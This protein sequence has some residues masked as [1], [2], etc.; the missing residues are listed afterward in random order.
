MDPSAT[1]YVDRDGAALAYQVTGDGPVDMV[2]FFEIC[3]HLDLQWTD[4]D[5]HHNFQHISTFARNVVFQRRGFGLSEQVPY[6]PTL[7]QQAGDVLAIMDAAGMRRA[8]LVGWMTTCGAV[9]LVAATAP[10]RVDALVLVDPVAQGPE[11]PG[12]LHGWTDGEKQKAAEALRLAID[13]WGTGGLV[14]LFDPAL[15]TGFNRQLMALLERSSATPAAA[16][17]NFDLVGQLDIEDILPSV[18]APTLVLG[19]LVSAWPE[20]AVR[21]VADLIPSSTFHVLPPSP[22]GTSLGRAMLPVMD[23][24]EEVATGVSPSADTDRFLGTVLFTDVVSSTELL[25]SVGDT[26]YRQLRAD[27][28]R[29]VRLAVD[30]AGGDLITVTGDGTL[31]VFDGPSAAVRCAETICDDA[32]EAGIAVRAGIHTGE[33]EREAMNVTGLTVHIG[34]RVGAAADPGQVLVSRTVHDLVA[35]SGLTFASRGEHEL[36]G[37]PGSWELFA[38]THAGDQPEALPRERSMQTPMDKMALQT[39]RKAP[40]LM[41]AAVRLGNAIERRRAGSS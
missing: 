14:N 1:Q 8:T 4:P 26:K 12:E 33:I 38:V 28:E 30:R 16:R 23:E 21:H 27:H 35:G 11:V 5:I 6:V 7:E 17:A 3:Q 9:A 36:K 10:E 41:R 20:A 29:L 18:Q 40:G 32:E 13:N 2:H 22:P 19:G 39:A 24:F 37:I 25:A 31:S 34:A 15:D